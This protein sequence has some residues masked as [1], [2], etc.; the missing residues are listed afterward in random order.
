MKPRRIF[1]PAAITLLMTAALFA[2]PPVGGR[3][4]GQRLE[5]LLTKTLAL[6]AVQQG[7]VHRRNYPPLVGRNLVSAFTFS[8][9]L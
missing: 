1:A 8:I 4:P 9:Q 5:N 2:Q 6:N 3:D 7:Q